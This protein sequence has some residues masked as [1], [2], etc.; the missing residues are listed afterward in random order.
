LISPLRVGVAVSTGLVLLFIALF[1]VEFDGELPD[2]F[3]PQSFCAPVPKTKIAPDKNKVVSLDFLI[4]ISDR[5][6]SCD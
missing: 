3:A 6:R 5:R 2:F 4:N 1:E